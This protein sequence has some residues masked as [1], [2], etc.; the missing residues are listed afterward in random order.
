MTPAIQPAP[1]P[2][3]D[4]A[5]SVLR[6]AAEPLPPI[7]NPDFAKAFDRFGSKR[8]VLLGEASHG[9]SE[10][11]RARAAITR[12]LIEEH[13]FSIVAVEADWP[14]AAMVDRYI[15]NKGR[16]T[17]KPSPFSRFPTWM[18]RNVEFDAFTRYLE[19]YNRA[20]TMNDRVAF[21]G[22][23]LYNMNAS[24][25]AVSGVSRPGRRSGGQRCPLALCVFVGMVA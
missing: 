1:A 9:T 12:R 7:N 5:G 22:L 24:I 23:D 8:V 6:A 25:A 11:Y 17:M 14:D 4:T 19:Q 16:R 10:F 20:R 3:T 21:Y 15:R 2:K 18:W 13:G